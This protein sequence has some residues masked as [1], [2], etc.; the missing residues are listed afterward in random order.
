LSLIITRW[1]DLTGLGKIAKFAKNHG[2]ARVM[3]GMTVASAVGIYIAESIRTLQPLLT[4]YG[5]LN[6]PIAAGIATILMAAFCLK[7]R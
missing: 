4:G 2:N 1:G 7:R 6:I 5:P 3:A